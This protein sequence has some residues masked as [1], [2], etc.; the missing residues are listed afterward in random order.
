[1]TPRRPRPSTQ[2]AKPR[3][4]RGWTTLG[5]AL[6]ALRLYW[7]AFLLLQGCAAAAAVAYYQIAWV[8]EVADVLAALKEQGGALFVA[9]ANVASG[10]LLPECLKAVLRPPGW[11]PLRLKEWAHLIGLFA[12]LGVAVDGF[13]RLQGWWFGGV[14]GAW[15]VALKILV[16]QFGYTLWVVM[17]LVTVWFEWKHQG[18]NCRRTWAALRPSL[19]AERIPALFVP[20]MIFWIPALAAL[21]SLPTAVQFLLFIFVNG[22]WCLI[23]VFVA[24][25][26]SASDKPE[27]VCKENRSEE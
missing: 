7:P 15:A 20:N 10:A 11:K 23:M 12:I 5:P 8:R 25:R 21:Y 22:A 17:P 26:I 19:F 14:G 27:T 9:V 24:S 1:M 2:S 3:P 6:E 4:A 13:Y 16:D 18:F